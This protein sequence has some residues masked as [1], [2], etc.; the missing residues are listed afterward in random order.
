MTNRK[1]LTIDQ[2]TL[3]NN[4]TREMFQTETSA[5]RHSNREADRYDDSASPAAA[6]R[7]V[8]THAERVLSE[9]PGLAERNGMIVSNGGILVGELFSQGRDKLADLLIDRERSYRG[10]LLGMRHGLDVFRLMHEFSQVVHNYELRDFTKQWLAERMPLVQRVE[11]QLA[12]FAQNAEVAIRL[13]GG[14]WG[15]RLRGLTRLI[16]H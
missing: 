14:A 4:L 7:G 2:R 11:E 16:A 10:T 1:N 12:W 9:L 15:P 5:L 6:L 3:L 8:A 13:G